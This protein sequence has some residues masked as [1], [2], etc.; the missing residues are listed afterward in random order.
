[1]KA[2]VQE[3]EGIH[4]D[5]QRIVF[6]GQELFG[7]NRISDYSIGEGA[8]LH[9]F[10]TEQLLRVESAWTGAR[11]VGVHP[12][13]TIANVKVKIQEELH[14]RPIR[15]VSGKVNEDRNGERALSGYTIGHL[16][17]VYA[18]GIP[19]RT[20]SGHLF[21]KMA[22]GATIMVPV[23]AQGAIDNVK[24]AIHER[25]GIPPDQQRLIHAGEQLDPCTLR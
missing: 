14:G 19:K 20:W 15:L 2:K 3:K 18:F 21:V 25:V 13:D 7:V 22:T 16:D 24:A 9:L 17:T 12:S 1:M 5:Q 23:G 4:P 6:A 8:V 10:A 11:L